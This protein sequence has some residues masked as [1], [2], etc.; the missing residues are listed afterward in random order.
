MPKRRRAVC[1]WSVGFAG[2][3]NLCI[4]LVAACGSGSDGD[5]SQA[6]PQPAAQRSTAI[7]KIMPLG[8]SITE[9]SKGQDSY[10][11]YLWHSLMDQGYQV[12]FVGSQEGVRN[13]VPANPDFDMDH[14]GHTGWRADEVLTHIEA[15][16]TATS[17]AVVLLHIGTNDICQEQTV[18]S[19][20]GD[21]RGIIDVLRTVNPRIRILIAQLIDSTECPPAALNAQLPALVAD[22]NQAE[23]PIVLV[24]QYTGFDPATMTYDG[25]HPNAAGDSHMADRWLEK[26]GPL[27]DAFLAQPAPKDNQ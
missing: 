10:R 2:I 12:D 1:P 17:P 18:S 21:I 23:S 8:D 15:W 16:A 22:K 4:G 13:G 20:V 27:L 3:L 11:F 5:T 6:A 25:T 7:V 9:S 24:D 19:T 14:E 26:L